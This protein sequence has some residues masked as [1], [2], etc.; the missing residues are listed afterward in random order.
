[1]K[2]FLTFI[3][4]SI[5]TIS[6]CQMPSFQSNNGID[7]IIK[8][9][10]PFEKTTRIVEKNLTKDEVFLKLKS[11][12]PNII[13]DLDNF[14]DLVTK[15]N[16]L[17]N[18]K[19]YGTLYSFNGLD[20]E[21]DS[22]FY[23]NIYPIFK[24][25][26][27]GKIM[28]YDEDFI[29]ENIPQLKLTV[30]EEEKIN[31][32]KKIDVSTYH[33]PFYRNKIKAMSSQIEQLE[34]RVLDAN[35]GLELNEIDEIVE[36][37]KVKK[38]SLQKYKKIVTRIEKSRP[39]PKR[40]FPSI[41]K[42]GKKITFNTLYSEI[43]SQNFY[44]VK[45]AT[46]QFNDSGGVAESELV[47]SYLGPTRV[48]LGSIIANANQDTADDNEEQEIQSTDTEA[49]QRLIAGGGNLY[50]NFELPIFLYQKRSFLFYFNGT[51]RFNLDVAE[52]SSDINTSTGNGSLKGN[53][54]LSLSTDNNVMSFFGN[55]S[56][57]HYFGHKT[58]IE[59]LN[60]MDRESFSFGQVTAG[61]T[62]SNKFRIAL[63][64]NTF[65]NVDSL[66]SGKVIIGAQILSGLFEN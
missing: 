62:V 52:F 47:T 40:F 14:N 2:T 12:K 11:L 41:R 54:Y 16:I 19:I 8:I 32:I 60:I 15:L 57:G 29:N 10:D 17:K 20:K 21:N 55:A 63:T 53:I 51:A 30:V 13:R 39:K 6:Y 33:L 23:R 25:N 45:N 26:D 61:L 59:K 28:D 44:F 5:I 3:F 48:T 58:F 34:K 36:V 31:N 7:S 46:F 37:I 65:G 22:I 42:G 35:S 43:G 27:V 1:M 24:Y 50:L 18:Q 64:L 56:F 38:D 9:D 49:F 66:N 4:C